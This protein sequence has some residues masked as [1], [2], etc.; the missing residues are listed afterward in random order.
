MAKLGKYF[1]YLV[2]G[3]VGIAVI[4]AVALTLFFNPNDFRDTISAQVRNATGR[5]LSIEGDL[6]ISVFPWLAVELGRTSLGNAEGF[7]DDPFVS[8][9][10]A[11]LSVRLLPLV[12]S[13]RIAVGTASLDGFEANLAV[14]AD[15]ATNWDDLMETAGDPPPEPVDAGGAGDVALDIANVSLRDARINYSDAQT[16]STYTITALNVGTGRIAAGEAFDVEGGLE[17]AA[18]P[19]E[20][21][22]EL[23]IS[24][25]VALGENLEQVNVDGLNVVGQLRGIVSQPTDFSFDSRSISLHTGRE[26]VTIGEIDLSVLGLSMSADVQPFSYAGADDLQAALRVAEFSLKELLTTLDVE[27]PATADPNALGKLSF[28]ADA[29]LGQDALS[30]SSMSLVMDDTTMTGE[31]AVPLTDGGALVFDLRAD[32][33]NVDNYMA[34]ASEAVEASEEEPSD[35]EIPVE[36]I[37]TL[38]ADGTVHLDEAFLGPVTFTNMALGVVGTGR[39]LRLHPITAEFFDG[40]YNG[41]VRI[42]VS[43]SV[44]SLSV[45]ERISGVNLSS[46]ARAMYDTENVTGTING[47]FELSG[48]GATLSAI[49]GDLDGTMRFELA[50]GAWEGTDVWHQLRSARALYKRETPPSPDCRC[51]PNSVRSPQP[52]TSP[53][54]FSR[55]TTC[56][57]RCRSCASPAPGRST[58]APARSTTP[59]RR[60]FWRNR[61]S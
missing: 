13:Q 25:S 36:L 41:D 8:F 3:I 15:G 27:A 38:K 59:C 49:S 19:G 26:Q 16:G 29:T 46:M 33:I 61:N 45:N 44:P 21:G 23:T 39:Q 34:P 7:G 17:F 10:S 1:L 11:R 22:G 40:S 32:T 55:T 60:A 57:R 12:F 51:V 48:A 50:D 18:A 53:T 37:R 5:E 52:A 56:S 47:G 9:D 2:A 28:E 24:A 30:L 54:A 14:A 42:D 20:L 43:G 58:S 4:A 6:S 35:V 31:L